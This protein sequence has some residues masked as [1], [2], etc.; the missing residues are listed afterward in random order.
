MINAL[1]YLNNLEHKGVTLSL[2][3]IRALLAKL[4]DPQDSLKCI[5]VAGT[6]GKGSVCAMMD[7]ILR[8]RGFKTGRFTSPHLK[9]FNE[10]I[11]VNNRLISN[12]DIGRLLKKIMPFVTNQTYFEVATA[13]AFL[14]FKEKKVDFA[15]LEVGLGGRLDATNV[16]KP[17]ISIITNVSYDHFYYLGNTLEKIAR[18]KAGIIKN[19]I[20]VITGAEGAALKVIKKTAKQKNSKL[21]LVK[22]EYKGKI[23]LDGNFQ[24][25]NAAIAVRALNELNI[26]NNKDIKKGLKKVKWPGRF[27]FRNGILFDCAHNL[28]GTLNLVEELRNVKYRKLILV[29]GVMK[30]KDYSG[31]IKKLMPL[32]DYVVLTKPK[33]DRALDPKSIAKKINNSFVIIEESKKALKFAK[34]IAGKKD[35]ILVT[36]S[37][38]LVGEVI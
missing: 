13:L 18:E 24:K 20:P 38:F 14:Y 30:D 2:D 6:N 26:I 5:H 36:G 8:E 10:R 12:K 16:V 31:M 32:A 9:S 11:R 33:I 22:N 7:F 19:K 1:K 29:F 27:E 28:A 17:T 3:R 23:N 34:S 25:E 4:D 21:I 15:V 35:L 37:I